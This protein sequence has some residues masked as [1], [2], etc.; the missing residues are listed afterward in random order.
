MDGGGD[1]GGHDGGHCGHGHGHGHGHGGDD[2]GV[3][4]GDNSRKG[5]SGPHEPGKPMSKT[6]RNLLIGG[7]VVAAVVILGWAYKH[8]KE[9]Q[10]PQQG[11]G[12]AA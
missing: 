11:A 2:G 9:Q 4:G 7:A 1:C 12:L 5:S 8:Q 10:N 3:Y 6:T